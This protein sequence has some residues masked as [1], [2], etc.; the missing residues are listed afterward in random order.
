MYKYEREYK[1]R[2]SM[3]SSK[4]LVECGFSGPCLTPDRAVG[5]TIGWV[6]VPEP[7]Q[8]NQIHLG[9]L[10]PSTEPG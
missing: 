5:V 2:H 4:T 8:N 1:C 3:E 6:D 10:H 7:E 9:L